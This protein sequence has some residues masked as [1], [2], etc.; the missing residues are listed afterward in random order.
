MVLVQLS[1]LLV[2]SSTSTVPVLLPGTGRSYDLPALL[3]QV[4]VPVY[5][6]YLALPVELSVGLVPGQLPLSVGLPVPATSRPYL[7]PVPLH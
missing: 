2:A 6:E 7:V 5:S 3:Y 1:V 4:L